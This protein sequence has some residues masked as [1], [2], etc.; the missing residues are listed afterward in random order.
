MVFVEEEI[1]RSCVELRQ[2]M[3]MSQ[4]REDQSEELKKAILRIEEV[5]NILIFL[6]RITKTYIKMN[7]RD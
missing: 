4:P 3:T 1:I 6:Q 2:A 7:T 5:L